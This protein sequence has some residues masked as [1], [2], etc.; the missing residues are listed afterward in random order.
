[1]PQLRFLLST[2]YPDMATFLDAASP[3]VDWQTKNTAT[4]R[5]TIPRFGVAICPLPLN[6][7]E[8]PSLTRRLRRKSRR[9]KGGGTP[10]KVK[11][12]RPPRQAGGTLKLI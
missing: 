5:R 6:V 3:F 11:L 4:S 12:L 2:R 10:V 7:S 1:M 8:E 9:R